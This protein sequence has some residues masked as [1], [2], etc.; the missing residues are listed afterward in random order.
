MFISVDVAGNVSESPV[1]GTP[2][3]HPVQFAA[4][5]IESSAAVALHEHVR[6]FADAPVEVNAIP[7]SEIR[8]AITT[9]RTI[10]FIVTLRMN[11][12]EFYLRICI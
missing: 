2:P 4:L 3:E 5:F 8:T 1:P 10:R 6:P 12:D 9:T 7:T 11:E